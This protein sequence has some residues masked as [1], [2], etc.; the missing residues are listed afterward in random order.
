MTNDVGEGGINIEKVRINI[1]KVG[2]K[3]EEIEHKKAAK[4]RLLCYKRARQ[5]RHASY[6][7]NV[8]YL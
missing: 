2:I 8:D 1:E 4:R 6:T 5:R 3:D 7:Q